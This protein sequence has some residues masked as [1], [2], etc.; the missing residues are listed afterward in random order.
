MPNVFD[1]LSK[2]LAPAV[3]GNEDIKKGILLQ[4]LGGTIKEPATDA[5]ADFKGPKIRSELNILL[6]GDPGTSKSQLLKY[7]YD[8]VPRAQ[9]TSGKGSSAV[10]LTAYIT[11]DADTKDLVLQS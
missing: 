5:S 6:C 9:Y 3:F 1:K 4:L 8:L 2:S 7:V 11:K 10:G